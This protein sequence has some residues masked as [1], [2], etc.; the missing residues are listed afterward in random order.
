MNKII[1]YGLIAIIMLCLSVYLLFNY[2]NILVAKVVWAI[3]T[4]TIG[5]VGHNNI[6]NI[7][8]ENERKQTY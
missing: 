3:G 4:I 7:R 1:G 6:Q 8:R 2:V 5:Y